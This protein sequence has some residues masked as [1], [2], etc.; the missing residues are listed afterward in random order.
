MRLVYL[1]YWRGRAGFYN[2]LVAWGRVYII[3]RSLSTI[4][5]NPPLSF[6]AVKF[7]K[8]VTLSRSHIYL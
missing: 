3:C 5:A 7:Q 2:L 6:F 8:V 1:I 4:L